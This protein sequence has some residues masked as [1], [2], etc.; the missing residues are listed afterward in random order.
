MLSLLCVLR[1]RL[2]L[3]VFFSFPYLEC[4]GLTRLLLAGQLLDMTIFVA[5]PCKTF[6]TT[7]TSVYLLLQ[8]CPNMVFDVAEF[9]IS[10]TALTA[11]QYLLAQAVIFSLNHLLEFFVVIGDVDTP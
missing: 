10:R 1:L 9:A 8:M 3:L 4:V 5:E 11:G 6:A 7:M 2:L